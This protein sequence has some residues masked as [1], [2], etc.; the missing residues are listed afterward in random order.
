MK[1]APLLAPL[2][3]SSCAAVAPLDVDR[4]DNIADLSDEIAKSY[5]P[6]V[7]KVTTY[8]GMN[9]SKYETDE[10]T[11]ARFKVKGE[12]DRY[13]NIRKTYRAYCDK[14]QG[15][16]EQKKNDAIPEMEFLFCNQDDT[17]VL[18]SVLMHTE[19]YAGS[20]TLKCYSVMAVENKTMSGQAFADKVLQLDKAN[21]RRNF[22]SSS[23][24]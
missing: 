1:K 2:I 20:R 3:L 15:D 22:Y 5:T 16:F 7:M 6:G 10:F 12:A 17:S 14:L 13:E 24:C 18:F 8:A 21:I 19:S 4:F 11:S 9:T 23:N